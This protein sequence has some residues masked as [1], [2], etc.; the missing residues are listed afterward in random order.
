MVVIGLFIGSAVLFPGQQPASPPRTNG[1]TGQLRQYNDS[2]LLKREGIEPDAVK[3]IQ[4]MQAA[5]AS[6][7][8]YSDTTEV[9]EFSIPLARQTQPGKT[10]EGSRQTRQMTIRFAKPNKIVVVT[11]PGNTP[12][13]T[14]D[15]A[16]PLEAPDDD[17]APGLS[18][19]R[20][21]APGG[22]T[23]KS[24]PNLSTASPVSARSVSD[25]SFFY[26]IQPSQSGR[27]LKQ[28]LST[29]FSAQA[30]LQF[31][32]A[33]SLFTAVLSGADTLKPP[34]GRQPVALYTVRPT[35]ING[36]MLDIVVA[37][38]DNTDSPGEPETIAY[39]ISQKDHL[40]RRI[41]INRFVKGERA[42]LMET[43]KEVEVDPALPA[44]TFTF[45]A[46]T[47]W[48]P[49]DRL[50]ASS[51]NTPSGEQGLKI[52]FL[53][54][55][56]QTTALDG[57]PISL[58]NYR[59][60]PVLLVFWASWCPSCKRELP[61]IKEA[62]ETYHNQGFEVLGVSLD[63]RQEELDAFLKQKQVPWRQIYDGQ[64][65]KSPLVAL[66]GVRSIPFSLLIGA[67]GKIAAVNPQRLELM[68]AVHQAVKQAKD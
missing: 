63:R 8:T 65:W 27:Y 4:Q 3:L 62:Y 42:I 52:G 51:G 29:D 58:R 50:K 30:L 14:A 35:K 67:D 20:I 34:W 68:S 23:K 17:I 61:H 49:T 33:G 5:Y 31:Q 18:G 19:K 44:S 60:K 26:S 46:P 57:K 36:E 45:Q 28:P 10:Q 7:K 6:L 22:D 56:I 54:P 39:E 9:R 24:S 2:G 38:F 48:Q 43:H 16:D 40:L 41:V 64:S 59:G 55:P 1:S 66:Y 15:T 47:G 11:L 21:N 53:P 12:A 37:R 13:R 32:P 25:G